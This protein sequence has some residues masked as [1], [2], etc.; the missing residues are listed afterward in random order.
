[1]TTSKHYILAMTALLAFAACSSD[2][3]IE[4]CGNAVRLRVSVG[5]ES[6]FTRSNPM[7]EADNQK[8]FNNGD[9]VSVSNGTQTMVYTFS[10]SGWTTADGTL[11]WP[12]GAGTFQAFYP[13]DG[14][15]TFDKGTIKT[16]Q[17]TLTN[18]TASDYMKQ[19]YTYTSVPADRTLSLEMQRQTARVIFYISYKNQFDG[20]NPSIDYFH[21]CSSNEIPAS[22]TLNEITAYRSG[23]NFAALVAPTTAKSNENFVILKVKYDGN[24]Y[25]D[26]LRVR[27]IPA[28]EAGKSYTYRLIVGKD[29]IIIDSSVK[30]NNWT[31]GE[32]LSGGSMVIK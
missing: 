3:G 15:N 30:V 7:G 25:G 24:T 20:L 31:T 21:V 2:E 22:S 9:M 23:N 18:L 10:S 26:E 5:S 4:D 13:A 8:S 28:L 29:E 17:S 27:G 11:L 16:D 32:V 1:M 14:T 12:E 6:V 19:T